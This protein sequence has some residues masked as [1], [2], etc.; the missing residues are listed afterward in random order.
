[1]EKEKFNFES[2]NTASI[3]S[4][5]TYVDVTSGVTCVIKDKF[6]LFIDDVCDALAKDD[7]ME[8]KE[9]LSNTIKRYKK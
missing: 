6:D 5:V 1:M 9:T 8:F 7:F 4:D 3:G 2:I